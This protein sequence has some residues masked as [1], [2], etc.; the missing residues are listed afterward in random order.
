VVSH[1]VTLSADAFKEE[2]IVKLRE[3]ELQLAF[4]VPPYLAPYLIPI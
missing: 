4:K 2:D 3:R 1:L